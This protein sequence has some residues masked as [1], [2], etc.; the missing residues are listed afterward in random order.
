MKTNLGNKQVMSKNLTYYIEKSGKSQKELAEMLGVSTSTFNSWVVGKNYL[1]I[2]R[3]E[4][5]AS[6]FGI[7]KSDL[8]EDH[9]EMQKKNDAMADI[10][11]KM[12]V[13]DSFLSVV[14]KLYTLDSEKL[15]SADE[16]LSVFLKQ[17]QNQV[18]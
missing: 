14:K 2:D 11:L 5:L 12:R 3:I 6:Y 17:F 1:R 15:A 8:I 16:L 18:K 13:D 7:M 10:I 9:E 4:M